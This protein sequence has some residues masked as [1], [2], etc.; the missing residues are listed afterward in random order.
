MT[1][2]HDGMTNWANQKTK[3]IVASWKRSS[4]FIRSRKPRKL[5]R[6]VRRISSRWWTSN[7]RDCSFPALMTNRIG[8]MAVRMLH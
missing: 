8:I 3:M 6:I 7:G 5:W 1:W 2:R 4:M